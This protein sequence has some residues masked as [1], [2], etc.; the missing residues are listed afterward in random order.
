MVC[1]FFEES[2]LPH[3]QAFTPTGPSIRK[4][5][6]PPLPVL[7]VYTCGSSDSGLLEVFSC[8][9]V[10]YSKLYYSIYNNNRSICMYRPSAKKH[11]SPAFYLSLTTLNIRVVSH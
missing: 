5:L 2:V 9:P 1:L 8:S 10:S 3:G 7:R 4:L 11:L 6:F